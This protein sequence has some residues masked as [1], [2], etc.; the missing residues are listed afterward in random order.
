MSGNTV[1]YTSATWTEQA[2]S[3]APLSYAAV[4]GPRFT[5]TSRVAG[6]GLDRQGGW[7]PAWRRRDHHAD[8]LDRSSLRP[9]ATASRW[10][11]S[12][13]L[14]ISAAEGNTH[15]PRVS[16]SRP[17]DTSTPPYSPHA[18]RSPRLRA[19]QKSPTRRPE[20]PGHHTSPRDLPEPPWEAEGRRHRDEASGS[21][22]G[23]EA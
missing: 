1:A 18:H 15:Y 16:A 7:P 5:G 22:E 14:A 17:R 10:P 11:G 9:Q 2:R 8:A 4:T 12:N 3:L 20:P 6:A 21:G 19:R 13:A 23:E